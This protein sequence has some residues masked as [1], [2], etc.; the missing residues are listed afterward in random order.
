MPIKN[1]WEDHGIYAVFSGVVT[2]QDIYEANRE[3]IEDPRS[4]SC[5]YQLV[6][7]LDAV[8]IQMDDLVMVDIAADDAAFSRTYKGLKVAMIVDNPEFRKMAEKYIDLSWKLNS[9][10]HFRIYQT[11]EEAREWLQMDLL[12]NTVQS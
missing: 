8:E 12:E 6:N 2:A 1:H 11:E 10:W 7:A 5:R 3:T 4:A 9:S